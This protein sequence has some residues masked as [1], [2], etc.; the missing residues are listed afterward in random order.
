MTEQTA[1]FGEKLTQWL[2]T[3]FPQASQIAIR[4]LRKPGGGFSNET[5]LFDLSWQV[6]ESPEVKPLVLRMAPSGDATFPDYDLRLQ[7][8]CMEALKGTGV[9]VPDVMCFEDDAQIFGVPFYLMAQIEG[10]APV[11]NPP[12]HQSG[13]LKDLSSSEQSEV[14][15]GCIDVLVS[16]SQVDWVSKGFDSLNRPALG[17]TPLDQTL[18]Y[19]RNFLAW[20]E[21][22][23]RPYPLLNHA[24]AWL[25]TNKPT[26]EPTTLCWGDAKLGN[27]LFQGSRCVAALDW[28]KPHLGNPVSDLAWCLM[29]DRAL[30]TSI[31]IERLPGFWD[32]ETTVHY[33]AEK[34]G[35]AT[36]HLPYYEVLAAFKFAV[37]MASITR[38]FIGHG[39]VP[40]ET[41]MDIQNA[42]TAV[43][44]D[45]AKDY[46]IDLT[47]PTRGS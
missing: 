44:M 28:E 30:S 35:F 4:N 2:G 17:S 3:R 13:W 37:I 36:T 21:G 15:K 38:V 11:E 12:Y 45:Y 6:G 9:P 47:V 40:E 31:G 24:L 39:W 42:G 27:C 23:R 34:S 33:W 14:W 19:L 25:E 8:H 32:R 5:W 22:Q 7:Y 29:L 18:T 26:Q 41:D 20:V 10:L 16:L 46:A 1:A 43:L